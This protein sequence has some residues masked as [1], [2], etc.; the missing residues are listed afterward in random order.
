MLY[1]DLHPDTTGIHSVRR[2]DAVDIDQRVYQ[3]VRHADDSAGLV[4]VD[5]TPDPDDT[6]ATQPALSR[7]V[8]A[9][10]RSTAPRQPC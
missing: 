2:V 1:D 4:V 5:D 10:H 8:A 6:P 3:L 9:C 7:L